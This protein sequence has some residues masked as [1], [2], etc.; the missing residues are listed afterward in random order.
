LEERGAA[1][2]TARDSMLA[3]IDAQIMET[4]RCY[5]T[6]RVT[7]TLTL[8]REIRKIVEEHGGPMRTDAELDALVETIRRA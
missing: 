8:W 7:D 2:M 1:T 3:L 4:S 5:L 6:K